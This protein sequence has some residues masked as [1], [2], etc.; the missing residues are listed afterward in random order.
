VTLDLTHPIEGKH[1]LLVEDI[2][3]TGI[4]MNYLKNSI[5]SR[6]PASLTTIALLE[7]PEALKV[8]CKLDY[9]GFQI[10]NE[11]VVGYGLDYEGYYRNLPYIGQ[12]QNFQ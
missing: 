9:V 6:K 4:T 8:P 5:M 3:D 10:T 1:V 2:V 12:V 11:F 7:K